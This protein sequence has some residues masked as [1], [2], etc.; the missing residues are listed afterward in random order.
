M[1]TFGRESRRARQRV[2]QALD[3]LR[4]ALEEYLRA[5]P[6][7]RPNTFRDHDLQRLLGTFIDR[8]HELRLDRRVRTLAFAAKDARNEIAHYTGTLTAD[9]ALRHLATVRGL[10]EALRAEAAFAE[11]DEL[12]QEQLRALAASN[13]PR[14]EASGH[15]SEGPSGAIERVSR[16]VP[17]PSPSPHGPPPDSTPGQLG[18]VPTPRSAPGPAARASGSRRFQQVVRGKYAPLFEHLSSLDGNIWHAN[19]DEI[20]ALLGLPLPSSARDHRPWWANGGHSQAKSW[21][22]AGWKTTNVDLA[23]GKLT[24]VR[25][26][27]RIP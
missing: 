6:R 4:V 25:S 9:E 20:E 16:A 7:V 5:L 27:D 15:A 23:A 19:F 8:F 26:E 11:V 1:R 12:Y 22:A 2:D 18:A 13:A 3:V 10:L 17:M 14:E 21:L 24:F